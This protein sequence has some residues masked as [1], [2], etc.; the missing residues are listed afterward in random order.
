LKYEEDKT[1]KYDNCKNCQNRNCEHFGKDREFVCINGISCKIEKAEEEKKMTYLEQIKEDIRNHIEENYTNEEISEKMENRDEFEEMLNDELWTDDNVT[2]NG[3][4]SYTFDR[5]KAQE[6]VLADIETVQEALREFCV[7]ADTIAE[8][9]LESDWE[10]FDVTARCYVL[11]MG[12][13]EVLDEI[14]ATAA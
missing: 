3:S 1:M 14:E 4:G 9:F 11:G 2:G 6:F 7:E 8:K 10:Y 13:S 12:I 5:S